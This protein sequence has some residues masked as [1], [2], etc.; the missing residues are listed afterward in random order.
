LFAWGILD[1]GEGFEWGK[2][3]IPG[4]AGMAD[5]TVDALQMF[6]A[7]IVN[8]A[9]SVPEGELASDATP[10]METVMR[11]L[12]TRNV[13][14]GELQSNQ[15]FKQE[16]DVIK[17]VS[18]RIQ[19]RITSSGDRSINT[20]GIKELQATITG[21]L[22]ELGPEQRDQYFGQGGSVDQQ[23]MVNLLMSDFY[24]D[25]NWGSQI[26]FG[27]RNTDD[28]FMRYAKRAGA[29]NENEIS[30]LER[31]AFRPEDYRKN[32][33][34][35]DVG[36]LEKAE[37]DVVTANLV[38]FITD[39]GGWDDANA[40]RKGM[41]TYAHTIGQRT[42]SERGYSNEDY[43]RMVTK[44]MQIAGRTPAEAPLVTTLDDRLAQSMDLVG[45]GS[46]DFRNLMDSLNSRRK[47]LNTLKVRNV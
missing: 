41:I 21:M 44:A 39:Q 5:R 31:G 26:F 4:M 7:D 27:S 9:L 36:A 23:Q 28:D 24:G 46:P 32:W 2:L 6:Q 22:G 25:N 38:K 14:I 13:N 11:R 16:E 1:P 40:L 17:E 45:G 35:N 18:R 42:A 47:S 29:L 43:G 15:A 19:E 3:D 10:Y 30:L 12:I 34:P 8:E 20:Q 33:D 37:Q